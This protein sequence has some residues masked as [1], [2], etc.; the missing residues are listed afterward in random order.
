MSVCNFHL[1]N[2]NLLMYKSSYG[3][4]SI[5]HCS[6]TWTNHS[7]ML[8]QKQFIMAWGR[9]H[10]SLYFIILH[11]TNYKLGLVFYSLKPQW[12]GS[13]SRYFARQCEMQRRELLS[14]RAC[15][16]YAQGYQ[17]YGC[18]KAPTFCSF[19]QLMCINVILL[20]I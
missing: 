1:D 19:C 12:F 4:L 6:C 8:C 13:I 11:Y 18:V 14:K 5:L 2:F 20:S 3:L 10:F 17:H 16:P 9:S 7:S 15:F